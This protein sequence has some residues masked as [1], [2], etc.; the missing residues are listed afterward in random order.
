MERYSTALLAAYEQRR[1]LPHQGE[2]E[3]AAS[4]ARIPWT[5]ESVRSAVR[6]A[7]DTVYAGKLVHA[8]EGG[9]VYLLL[10]HVAPDAP[11]L[12]SQGGWS[13]SLPQ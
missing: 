8:L 5:E 10:H 7:D 2:L 4:L 12:H 6:D 3:F 1:W 13:A 9:S 11:A